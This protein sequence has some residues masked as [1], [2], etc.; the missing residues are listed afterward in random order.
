MDVDES[1]NLSLSLEDEKE[2]QAIADF[3]YALSSADRVRV[4]RS[5]MWAPK[6]VS[7]LS[8]ETG[9]PISTVSRYLQDLERGGEINITYQPGFKGHTRYCEQNA[10]SF[11]LNM[12]KGNM[13]KEEKPKKLEWVSEMPIGMYYDCAI[14][15]PCGMLGLE[16]SLLPDN[17][18]KSFFSPQ[19]AGA[20]CIWFDTGK[21]SYKFPLPDGFPKRGG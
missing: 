5:L 12:K 8:Q 11:S 15:A 20:E 3:C 1:K 2:V 9:I 7:S 21:L 10:L 17:K 13:K 14:S 4:L 19:R 6:N 16:G 18:P